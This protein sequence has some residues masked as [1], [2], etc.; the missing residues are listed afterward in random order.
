MKIILVGSA[1][2]FRGGLAS[3]NERLIRELKSR[4]HDASIVTF[5]VQYPNFLFPGKTQFSSSP[6]P[7]DISIE[8]KVNSVYPLNWISVGNEIRK[9]KP[10]LVIFK[11]W[12]PF[13]GPCFG[14][15]ARRVKKNKHTKI[16]T[17]LDNVIPH[18]KRFGDKPFTKYFLKS[19][20]LFVAMSKSVMDD[21]RIF[22]KEKPC[23]LNPHPVF[24]NF[25]KAISKTEAKKLLGLDENTN[26]LLFFGFIRDYKGLDWMLEAFADERLKN[27]PVKLLVA[28]EFYKDRT[29]YDELVS[30]LNLQDR[31]VLK[32]D[33]IADEEVYK[34]FSAADL[35]VQPYKHATQSGVTQIA[36][37]FNKPMLVT[38]VGGLGELVPDGKV[39]YVVEPNPNAI[40][41]ALVDFYQNK[42]ENLFLANMEEEKKRFSWGAMAE[43]IEGLVKE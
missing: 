43:K 16:L 33:F 39:G 20:D 2:P 40:A 35:V 1:F 13:M 31:V 23:E 37:N 7:T 27:L 11:Y 18:E 42:K 21:L 4:G 29:M 17:I 8:R 32:T 41:N 5:T 36:Y 12:L 9:Q 15:I 30:K 38:N 24:D 34:Y 6:A 22:E 14:T 3:F 28:G 25:G 19:S 10:D 26:Y